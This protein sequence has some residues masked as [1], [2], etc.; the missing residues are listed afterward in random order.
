MT[1]FARHEYATAEL[2]N[3]RPALAKWLAARDYPHR[4]SRSRNVA[5][6]AGGVD[7]KPVD[8]PLLLNGLRSEQTRDD[9]SGRWRKV[10]LTHGEFNPT[11]DF[12]S[13]LKPDSATLPF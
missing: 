3:Y 12:E 5:C 8:L 9:P 4:P 7:G 11:L 13:S 1:C 2:G 10:G 6:E